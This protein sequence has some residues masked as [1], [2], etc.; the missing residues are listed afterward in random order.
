MWCLPEMSPKDA[1]C[2][3]AATF[4]RGFRNLAERKES[5]MEE[6]HLMSDHGP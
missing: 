1:V 4:R 5:R 2:P 3:V 6:G